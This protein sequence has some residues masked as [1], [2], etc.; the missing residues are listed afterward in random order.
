MLAYNGTLLW[1][2]RQPHTVSG[3]SGPEAT[4]E[5]WR[6]ALDIWIIDK[7]IFSDC[8][9]SHI[10]RCLWW[11][12]GQSVQQRGG[13]QWKW[14]KTVSHNAKAVRGI[15]YQGILACTIHLPCRWSKSKNFF[16]DSLEGKT[17]LINISLFTCQEL[18]KPGFVFFI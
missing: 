9:E 15:V 14:V 4:T 11:H 13:E 18:C 17:N 3:G 10:E 2:Q 5:G 8:S 6:K 7:R 1:N 12:C 16:P